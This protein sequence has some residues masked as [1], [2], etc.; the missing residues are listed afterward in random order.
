[1][2]KKRRTWNVTGRAEIAT[3]ARARE[4]DRIWDQTARERKSIAR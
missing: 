2:G 1:M 4:T 3:R